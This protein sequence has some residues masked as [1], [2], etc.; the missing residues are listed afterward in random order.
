[1]T[2]TATTMVATNHDDQFAEIYSVMLNEIN[3]TFGVSFF[4]FSLLWP[5]WLWFVAIMVCGHHGIG[6]K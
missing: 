4:T 2:M 3:S 1:M 5:S 6:P